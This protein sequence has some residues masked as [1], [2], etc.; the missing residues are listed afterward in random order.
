MKGEKASISQDWTKGFHVIPACAGAP[1][2]FQNALHRI[3]EQLWVELRDEL[4]S[5][6]GTS[7]GTYSP[8]KNAWHLFWK[9]SFCRPS[10]LV[11]PSGIFPPIYFKYFL[12]HSQMGISEGYG[13]SNFSRLWIRVIAKITARG[14]NQHTAIYH[15]VKK[16]NLNQAWQNLQALNTWQHSR[17]DPSVWEVKFFFNF[18]NIW[19]PRPPFSCTWP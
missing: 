6:D 1:T 10:I 3:N 8:K 14:E 16:A 19:T 5:L 9:A 4:T 11:V 2:P 12:I 15:V 13:T 17:V 18:P 7:V